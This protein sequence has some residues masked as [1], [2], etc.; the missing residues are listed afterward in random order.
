MEFIES[1]EKEV[2][3]IT[4]ISDI[5]GMGSAVLGNLIFPKLDVLLCGTDEVKNALETMILKEQNYKEIYMCDLSFPLDFIEKIENTSLKNK[6]R[7]FDHHVSGICSAD[8]S[9]STVIPEIDGFKPSGTSLFYE[10]LCSLNKYPILEKQAVKEFVEAIRSYDTW[11]FEQDKN[12]TGRYLTDIFSMIGPLTFISKYKE[13]LKQL[14]DKFELSDFDK[15]LVSI[16]EKEMERYIEECDENLIKTKFLDYN[17]GITISEQFRSS[18]GNKL[19]TKYKDIL[20]FILIV[21][22]HRRSF[23]MRTVND[24]DLSIIAKS[25]GG[26]GHKKA[27]GFPMNEEN[28]DKIFPLLQKKLIKK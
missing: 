3:I 19:S 26:G 14:E 15:E 13:H 21:D 16:K 20:D 25:L 5:D 10:Y 22:F 28:I 27:A 17:V 9:W 24:V 12:Y 23:S 2:L 11:T 7:H 6:F 8:Y 18:V 4:H 1:K